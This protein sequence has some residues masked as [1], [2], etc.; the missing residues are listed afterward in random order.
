M[1]ADFEADAIALRL[2]DAE[3]ADERRRVE[4]AQSA[5]LPWWIAAVGVAT[6]CLML[7]SVPAIATTWGDLEHLARGQTRLDL[8]DYPGCVHEMETVLEHNGRSARAWAYEGV[9]YELR[10]DG[11]NAQRALIQAYALNPDVRLDDP[12]DRPFDRIVRMRARATR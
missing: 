5:G 8:F 4:T 2:A 10:R 3:A 6:L 11:K 9:C 1:L 12:P 7:V